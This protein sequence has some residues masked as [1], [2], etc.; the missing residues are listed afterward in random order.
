MKK[1]GIVLGIV[2]GLLFLAGLI[3]VLTFDADRYRPYLESELEKAL[4]SDVAIDRIALAWQGGIALEARGISVLNPKS[5]TQ[6]KIVDIKSIKGV[7][8][9]MPLLNRQIQLA[10]I[11]IE[12][13]SAVL[14]RQADGSFQGLEPKVE[15]AE[16]SRGG[17]ASSEPEKGLDSAAPFAFLIRE[18]HVVNGR[19]QYRD[20]AMAEALEIKDIDIKLDKVALNT[21]MHV[22]GTAA[23]A[24]SSQNIKVQGDVRIQTDQQLTKLEN[25]KASMDL[26][27]IDIESVLQAFQKDN[28]SLPSLKAAGWV[29]INLDELVLGSE[30]PQKISFRANV[31]QGSLSSPDFP[32]PLENMNAEILGDAESLE[33]TSLAAEFADG[34]VAA[35]GNIQDWLKKAPS[36]AFRFTLRNAELKKMTPAPKANEPSM[37]GQLMFSFDGRANPPDWAL[38]TQH[39]QG[40]IQL[41]IQDGMILNLNLLKEILN[42][43]SIIPGLVPRLMEKMPPE[44]E[45][46]IQDKDTKLQPVQMAA[47]VQNGFLSATDL[48]LTAEEFTLLTSLSVRLTD[49]VLQGQAFLK[50]DPG[51]SEAMIRTVNE[52]QYLAGPDRRIEFPVMLRGTVTEPQFIPDIQF[53]GKKLAF[54]KTQ[55][56][57][58]GWLQP[59]RETAASTTPSTQDQTDPTAQSAPAPQRTNLFDI[60]LENVASMNAPAESSGKTGPGSSQEN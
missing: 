42:S 37:T 38:L 40:S 53:I 29:E 23:F 36:L 14:I 5:S 3:F 8:E 34:Q 49:L 24:H 2:V 41:Q 32:A 9:L 47:T 43:I 22:S 15:S 17:D 39:T 57:V 46:K 12:Q 59:K 50:V 20:P 28:A 10:S 4:G 35:S 7:L 27:T 52:L 30:S 56:L 44:Y 48:E 1:L 58:S 6:E 18:V 25:F 11:I 51:L 60:L 16:P 33:L 31:K 54:A 19:V 45:Q 26:S 55:E 13:P 21:P